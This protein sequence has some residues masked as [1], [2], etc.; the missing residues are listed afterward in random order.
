[1]HEKEIERLEKLSRE[2]DSLRCHDY[3]IDKL[4][5]LI[6]DEWKREFQDSPPCSRYFNNLKQ[7]KDDELEMLLIHKSR[8]R[9]R[10][11]YFEST[12]R[13][14]KGDISERITELKH[15]SN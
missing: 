5:A 2:V 8:P 15:N 1:M 3:D 6:K 4:D 10:V 11:S 12:V 7:T 14:F 13:N 9:L